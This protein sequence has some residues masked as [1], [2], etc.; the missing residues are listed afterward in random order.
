MYPLNVSLPAPAVGFALANDDAEHRSLTDA[1]YRP[2]YVEEADDLR[3]PLLAQA[4][5]KGFKVDKR[6]SD[7]RL[8]EELAKLVADPLA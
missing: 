8:A 5:E 7:A 2:A 6:W 3:A 1:G 4:A